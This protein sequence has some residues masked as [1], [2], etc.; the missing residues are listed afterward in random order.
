MTT[1]ALSKLGYLVIALAGV[2]IS[3][4]WF[5]VRPSLFKRDLEKA[6]QSTANRLPVYVKAGLI[7]IALSTAAL[8]MLSIVSTRHETT[9]SP[10]LAGASTSASAGSNKVAISPDQ[11]LPVWFESMYITFPRPKPRVWIQTA[12]HNWLETYE[13]QTSNV[14]APEGL[15]EYEGCKGVLLKKRGEDSFEVLLPY[16]NCPQFLMFRW[17]EGPWQKLGPISNGSQTIP[18]SSR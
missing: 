5:L 17:Q 3:F 4:F 16:S 6:S 11:S 14:F 12:D 9:L 2:A 18:S 15:T 13:G 1:L 10:D 7:G 8:V